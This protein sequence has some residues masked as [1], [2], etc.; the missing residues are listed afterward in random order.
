MA[1]RMARAAAA[2][3]GQSHAHAQADEET[4]D[5]DRRPGSSKNCREGTLDR[6]RG[7]AAARK[8]ARTLP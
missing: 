4:G 1:L 6:F 7:G 2:M 3:T 8:S 5:L